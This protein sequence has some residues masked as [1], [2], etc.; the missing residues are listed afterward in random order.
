MEFDIIVQ[1]RFTMKE[2]PWNAKNRDCF[3]P[4]EKY[5]ESSIFPNALYF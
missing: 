5:S 2:D 1:L 3:K 4:Q